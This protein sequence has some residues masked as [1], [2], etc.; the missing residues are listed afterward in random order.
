MTRSWVAF[1]QAT[2]RRIVI[3]LAI[4]VAAGVTAWRAHPGIYVERRSDFAQ[5]HAAAEAFLAGKDPYATIGP[6]REYSQYFPLFYPF[7][8][9]LVGIPFTWIP[10]PDAAFV[11]LGAG[12]LAWALSQDRRFRYA[13]WGL[14]TPA[15]IYAVRMT[16]WSPI[17]TAA[18]LLPPLGFLLACKPTIGA[19]LWLAFPSRRALVGGIAFALL[20][21]ALFPE[22][23]FRWLADMPAATHIRAPITFLG[24]PLLLLG[25]V[26]W[27][28]WDARLLTA[29]ACVPQT[30][31]LY[32]TLPL[33]LIPSSTAQGALLA[34]LN[35]GVV[36]ARDAS[37][38]PAD[39]V[40][41]TALTGQWMV[42][43]M[44]FPC[45][46]MVLRRPNHWQ[47]ST[48]AVPEIDAVPHD[49]PVEPEE[50]ERPA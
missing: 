27:R 16:Q 40:A 28:R 18:A 2:G 38:T 13:W 9:V 14:I 43:L 24:G 17:V 49:R 47:S 50:P 48:P 39:Y 23:P 12:L 29:L 11:A 7:T 42:W 37:P 19:A 41:D 3:A 44:Y 26:K 35:Y 5:I 6:Q 10:K 4:A 22:W 21:L 34:A 46:I 1:D 32:E 33:F 30:P 45:L 20:S 25:A 36:F 31:E 8:A 15:F